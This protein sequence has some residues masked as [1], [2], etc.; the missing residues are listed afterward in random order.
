[1]WSTPKLAAQYQIIVLGRRGNRLVHRWRRPDRPR[2]R[3]AHQVRHPTVARMGDRRIRQ[4]RRSLLENSRRQRP[5]R[6][7]RVAGVRAT[8]TSTSAKKTRA[9]QDTSEVRDRGRRRSGSSVSAKDA[10]R[11]HQHARIGPALS[12]PTNTTTGCAFESTASC[13]RSLSRRWRSRTSWLVAHQGHFSR[14]DISRKARA[15]RRAHEAQVRQPSRSTSGSATLPTLF[16]EKIVIRILDPSSSAK[17]GI[18]ALGYEKIEKGSPDG[19]SI[20]R[21]IRHGAGDRPNGFS[22]K[23][24]SLYTCLN[25]LNQPGVNISTVEDPAEIN[26]PGVNQV[27]VN[28]KAGMNFAVALKA[29]PAPGSRT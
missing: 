6:S 9:P 15:A 23:T 3:R 14:L 26:L 16:G 11:C 8:S 20:Q 2:G 7:H 28:D 22:G 21:P 12:S 4:A 19:R 18:E 5:T 1:M 25:I 10:D 27:N 29:F 17:L 24:V 13:A